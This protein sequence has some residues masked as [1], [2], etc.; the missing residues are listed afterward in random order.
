MS[1][2]NFDDV[3]D[4]ATGG[5]GAM[6]GS[7]GNYLWTSRSFGTITTTAVSPAGMLY[8]GNSNGRIFAIR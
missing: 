3:F 5:L 1:A 4:A 2:L 7:E 6:L 8:V